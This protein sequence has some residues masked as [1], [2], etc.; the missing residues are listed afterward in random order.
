SF[1]TSPWPELEHPTPEE[2]AELQQLLTKAHGPS[3][4]PDKLIVNNEVSGCGEVPCVLDALLRTIMS[5]NTTTKNSAKAFQDLLAHFGTVTVEKFLDPSKKGRYT[6]GSV[7]SV[8]WDAIR[9]S[10]VEDVE[11]ALKVG[12]LQNKKARV[13]QAILRQDSGSE[14]SDPEDDDDGELSLDHFHEMDNI[15]LMKNL[16]AFDGIGPKAAA[17]VMLFS[18]H[19]DVFPV[20]T[21]VHRL[22]K[23]LG[24]V[25]PNATEVT[26]FYHLDVRIPDEYK[27]SLHNLLIRHGRSCK[28]CAG[29]AEATTPKKVKTE[30]DED[31][32]PIKAKKMK[33]VWEGNGLMKERMVE[34]G[35]DDEDANDDCVINHLVNRV[36][37]PRRK[38][39][40][41][42]IKEE[43]AD[44]QDGVNV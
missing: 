14:L 5:L 36:R 30:L 31:G 34:L 25:P 10:R 20:D 27:Y 8:D 3:E 24:W 35:T 13:I 41:K 38:P 11:E 2:C 18:L 12:G 22:T 23:F 40:S 26:G 7:D 9:T 15:T 6:K 37:K 43:E 19:R 4:R 42:G 16:T 33:V 21:H 17:C 44:S 28:K 39:K 29:R 1:G 32:N